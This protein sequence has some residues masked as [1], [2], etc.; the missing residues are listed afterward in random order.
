M[1]N[2]WSTNLDSICVKHFGSNTGLE[3][4]LTSDLLNVSRVLHPLSVSN[5]VQ[6]GTISCDLDDF[7]R[8]EV[9]DDSSLTIVVTSN[10]LKVGSVVDVRKRV[11]VD[12]SLS[13]V[14]TTIAVTR[15]IQQV[16]VSR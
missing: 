4:E 13:T 15:D 3:C 9:G 10:H 6:P 8:S 5:S 16:V 11:R 12:G 1:V 14:P 7:T 2:Y